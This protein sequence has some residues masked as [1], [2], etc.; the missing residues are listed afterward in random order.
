MGRRDL[1]FIVVCIA[2]LL[3]LIA[4]IAPHTQSRDAELAAAGQLVAHHSP[5]KNATDAPG[6]GLAPEEAAAVAA[7]DDVFRRHWQ[8]I[9]V[10]PAPVADKLAIARRL[11]LAL[12]GTIPSLEDVRSLESLPTATRLA[13]WR[14]QLLGQRRTADY[15]AER[16]ARPLVGVE[17]GPFLIFRRRRFV[18]WLAD[19]LAENRP[20][21]TVVRELIATNGLWTDQPATNFVTAAWLVDDK[22]I[23]VNRL[24]S[25]VS[26]AFLGTRID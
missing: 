26:R 10:E 11:S 20:Y 6:L 4:R 1:L 9:S 13:W 8:H 23:D 2:G 12:T 15:L 18:T 7:V 17:D 16:L 22:R 14:E 21:D 5:A 3:A 19:A 24:A 25:R